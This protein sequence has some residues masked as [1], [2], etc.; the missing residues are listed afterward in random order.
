MR[1]ASV[2][3]LA[4]FLAV[5]FASPSRAD[6]GFSELIRVVYD[7]T[8]LIEEATDLGNINT[9]LAT[10][11]SQTLGSGS[12]AFHL[13]D[14]GA[15]SFEELNVA[16]FAVAPLSAPGVWVS[17]LTAPSTTGATYNGLVAGCS[18][19]TGGYWGATKTQFIGTMVPT[20]SYAGKSYW[21]K[22]D[23]GGGS[24]VGGLD[25]FI[26]GNAFN[27]FGVE[28]ISPGINSS[29]EQ[30]LY[31]FA[32]PGIQS[33][34][35][36]VATLRTAV[37]GSG[38]GC[39][40]FS[41]PGTGLPGPPVIGTATARDG[42]AT[43]TFSAPASD[44]GSPILS[45]TATSDPDGL[46]GTCAGNG[47]SSV[48]VTGLMDGSSYTFTVTA[49]NANGT[50][51]ASNRSNSVT[52]EVTRTVPGP[53]VIGTATAGDGQATV[54][55][56]APASDGGSPI[57]SYTA[58]SNP[59]SKSGFCS[60]AACTS[61]TITG[62]ANGTSYTFTVA[63]TNGVG[64][65]PASEASNKVSPA[66]LHTLTV[67][68]SGHGSGSVL[69]DP[70]GIDC[71][72]SC[73]FAYTQGSTITLTAQPSDERSLFSAWSGCK[74][75]AGNMCL[76]VM[77]ANR[78]VTAVFIPTPAY[79]LTVSPTAVNGGAGTITSGDGLISCG[80]DCNEIY[81]KG[82]TVTL[83]ALARS[84]SVF[85]GWQPAT[86]SCATTGPCVLT[87]NRAKSVRA[88]FVGDY[89]LKVVS[90]S[91]KAGTASGTGTVTCAPAGI[92]CSTGSTSGCSGKVPYHTSVTLVAAP[93]AG[94]A[95]KGWFGCPA[96]SG[97]SCT[98]TMD[99]AFTIMTTFVP[100][101]H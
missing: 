55:F 15:S 100:A 9:L 34:G 89:P 84:G 79:R 64:T 75:V 94:S 3:A 40:V 56:S 98:L 5:A 8:T 46:T 60:G 88:I 42:Q 90:R 35:V 96:P 27:S 32:T 69:S 23:F 33:D 77:A 81:L 59:G 38:N 20:G 61:I 47:C 4:A 70:S 62:L 50:G 13:A 85:K 92:A 83:T 31:Y 63:A 57:L 72:S 36:E 97:L 67:G 10:S 95:L 71:G 29:A 53:P 91:G 26:G 76:V 51:A 16:Y 39:T 30:D 78:T 87:M 17:A 19:V 37:D 14:F 99:R 86:A 82:K 22:F 21:K 49:T 73:S 11:G 25:G 2:C 18:A 101:T 45:Y 58:L 43:V 93:G 1:H 68:K 74:S 65:G 80:S 28:I 52:L 12:L 44:G 24:S 41:L 6:F 48:N 66:V 54:T 7:E